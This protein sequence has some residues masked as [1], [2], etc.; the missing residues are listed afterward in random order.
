M[1]SLV[2]VDPKKEYGVAR[3]PEWKAVQ[4]GLKRNLITLLQHYRHASYSV[5]SD[6]LLV[7]FLQSLSVPLSLPSDRYYSNV[8][9]NALSVANSLQ[10]TTPFGEGQLFKGVFFN[11]HTAEVVIAFDEDFDYQHVEDHWADAT[12]VRV[13]RHPFP[14]VTLQVPN[15]RFVS[16]HHGVA[17][18]AVNVSLL[19]VQHRAFRLSEQRKQT[20]NPDYVQR[21]TMQ[22]IHMFVLPN[23]LESYLDYAVFNRIDH[24][25]N[26]TPMMMLP[27]RDVV[28]LPNYT[29]Q[30]DTVLKRLLTILENSDYN[31]RQLLAA[32]PAVTFPDMREV[33]YVPDVAPTR[34]ILWSVI[35]ARLP[36]LLFMTRIAKKTGRI[37][38]QAGL[39]D[40]STLL[41]RLK[42]QRVLDATLPKPLH[43]PAMNAIN[44]ILGSL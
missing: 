26:Q 36:M 20:A 17:V 10:F 11:K 38:N 13:V 37:R 30:V 40:V 42:N 1:Y 35:L 19:A 2:N 29:R 32:I 41:I 7:K 16:P 8:S 21:N 27:T 44:E 4:D 6:H 15:G 14:H 33:M 39:A 24:L 34:Q 28:H 3:L 5:A 12:P 9:I 25:F 31:A 22:F 18:I 23:M 43:T